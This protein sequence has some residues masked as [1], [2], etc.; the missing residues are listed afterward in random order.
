MKGSGLFPQGLRELGE[1]AGTERLNAGGGE[2]P[3]WVPPP[4]TFLERKTL[5]P[6]TGIVCVPRYA[7]YDAVLLPEI[8]E[9]G[10]SS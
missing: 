10:L 1:A 5:L 7:W 6:L 3:G 2:G 8:T 9:S 4:F